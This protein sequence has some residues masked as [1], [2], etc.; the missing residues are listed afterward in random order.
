[1]SYNFFLNCPNCKT[2]LDIGTD[3]F[4]RSKVYRAGFG[5]LGIRRL[6]GVPAPKAKDLIDSALQTLTYYEPE[7]ETDKSDLNRATI[8]LNFLASECE[9]HPEMIFEVE[10]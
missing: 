10:V 4:N 8:V 9:K 6:N 1:M 5:E 3:S 7:D 2:C